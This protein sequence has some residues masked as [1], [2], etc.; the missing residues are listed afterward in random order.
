MIWEVSCLLIH[1]LFS[2]IWISR[3]LPR[4]CRRKW[5]QDFVAMRTKHAH[6]ITRL[7]WEFY[8]RQNTQR[9]R[10]K[11]NILKVALSFVRFSDNYVSLLK[12]VLY[13]K[14]CTMIDYVWYVALTRCFKITI[15][16][17]V[18]SVIS[19]NMPWMFLANHP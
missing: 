1:I 7:I 17:R 11:M 4:C 10:N 18:L 12:A 8:S 13:N 9:K 2:H 5:W 14:S 15:S 6:N 19:K 16:F 3:K